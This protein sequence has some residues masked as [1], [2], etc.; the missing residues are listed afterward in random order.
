MKLSKKYFISFLLFI[1]CILLTGC[2][3]RTS[4]NSSADFSVLTDEIFKEYVTSDSITLNYTLSDP[5]KYGISNHKPTLGSY[6]VS[7]MK[8]DAVLN[9]NFYQRLKQ[10]DRKK[11]S[12]KQQITYDILLYQFRLE[13]S[14]NNLYLYSESL[15]P[16][17]GIQAQ[18]PVLLAEYNFYSK[19]E[20][21]DYEVLLARVPEY[22]NQI[23]AFEREK[24][25]AGLFMSDFAVNDIVQQCK[26]FI[27]LKEENFL[28][29]TFNDKIEKFGGI[30]EGEK[31][32]FKKQNRDNILK[33]LIPA[34]ENLIKELNKLRGTGKNNQGLSGL[35]DGKKY[36][37]YLAKSQTGSSR[38]VEEQMELLKSYSLNSLKRLSDM[39]EKDP[40][41]Y[42]RASKIKYPAT[43]PKD[44]LEYLSLKIHKNYP[45][46]P[47]SK[48]AVKYVH[49]SLE[50][51]LSPAFYLTP[52]IDKWK[53]NS[54][55]INGSSKY[56]RSSLF[57]TLAHEG[58]P[59]HLYQSVY[60]NS[61]NPDP[62]RSVLEF[63]G[64]SEGWA[65]Y[66][67][68]DSYYMAGFKSD[69]AEFLSLNRSTSLTIS[70]IVD[71]GVNYYGW[72]RQQ[73][74]DYLEAT[75]GITD[76]AK[77]NEIYNT[78][79]EEPANYVKYAVGFLEFNELEK[80]AEKYLKEDYNPKSF[81]T[82]L[83]KTG[84]APFK[85]IDKYIKIWLKSQK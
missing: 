23:T 27:S 63:G 28:I 71:I 32:T 50:D 17:I 52:P 44:I 6:S 46:A 67:E 54:I 77:L 35:P 45:N 79:V 56:D 58:Y 82:F 41:L 78:M 72:S 38:S 59:G 33:Y 26:K 9:E 1:W 12:A 7:S 39:M 3:H 83:L 57:P 16:T 74:F 4:K 70:A 5:S 24:S 43:E 47:D 62:V 48:Y 66:V 73:S 75:M 8:A 84:P 30:T 69:I 18:L 76:K 2:S 29:T 68:M 37:T 42:D 11:L 14:F 60:F 22:F 20:I 81:H 40:G 25:K 80:K 64:Y 53:N 13:H 10:I 65:T 85:V 49:K 36:Y 34:Y 51:D 21:E 19:K 31:E 61:T 15:S 55:Y